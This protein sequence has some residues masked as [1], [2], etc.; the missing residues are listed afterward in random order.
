MLGAPNH[1]AGP[2]APPKTSAAIWL[3]AIVLVG[4]LLRLWLWRSRWINPDEGAHLMDGRLALEGLVPLV[5][6]ASRQVLYTYILAGLIALVGPDYSLVRLCVLLTMPATACLVFAIGRRLFDR[7]VGLLAAAI[8]AF[9][10]LAIVWA[11]IVHTEPFATLAACLAMYALL[12]HLGAG[13]TWGALAVAGVLFGLAYYIRESSLAATFA[14]LCTLALCSRREPARLVRRVAVLLAGFLAP[15]AAF[16]L[17]YSRFLRPAQWWRSPLNPLSLVATQLGRVAAALGAT[18]EGATPDTLRLPEQPWATTALYLREIASLD[19]FLLVGVV[20]SVALL[21][22]ATQRREELVALRLPGAL[23]YPWL[24]GLTLVYGYWSLHRGFFPQYSEEFLPGLAILLA[25][26][27]D[28]LITWW[29]GRSSVGWGTVWLAI[30]AGIAFAASRLAPGL[31]LPRPA[32][33][34]VPAVGFAWWQ[35]GGRAAWRQWLGVSAIAALG[36]WG[37]TAGLSLPPAA[38][39]ALKLLFVPALLALVWRTGRTAASARHRSFLAYVGVVLLAAAVGYSYGAA[40]RIV[41]PDYETVWTPGTVREIAGYLRTHSQAGDEAMSGAVIWE[42][43][44]DRQ[45]FAN[46]SHPLEFM[47]GLPPDESATLA[48]RLTRRPPRFV[49]LDGY[50]E[51]S[52]GAVLPNLPRVLEQRYV[53]V[54]SAFGSY[55]PVRVYR[56][57]DDSAR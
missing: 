49:V 5:D 42:L 54:D 2:E 19:A 48:S 32:Y 15:C 1:P 25:F 31:D 50:T 4:F 41:R 33:V 22:A 14:A 30:W 9:T 16:A 55:Y 35:L 24:A 47:Y 27:V 39:R 21:L 8:F 36:V 53:V 17:L 10:P 38:A 3:V 29:L 18:P 51:R 23:L 56:L 11:P 40:A 28:R 57:R 26:V 13:G 12:R 44:A 34:A 45:P 6:F 37:L 52:Y 46:I 43:Q 20:L 7:R